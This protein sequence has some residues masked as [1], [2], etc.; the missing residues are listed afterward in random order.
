VLSPLDHARRMRAAAY[1]IGAL[2]IMVPLVE[3]VFAALP[4]HLHE[5]PWRLGALNALAGAVG[6]PLVG[7]FL[8]FAIALVTS[9]RLVLWLVFS[10]CAVAGALCLVGT[11]AFALDALQMHGQV[12]AGVGTKYWIASGWAVFKISFCALAFLILAAR[13]VGGARS[14]RRSSPRA[15]G[16][17]RP[18]V[19]SRLA[20]SASRSRAPEA[21]PVADGE[22]PIETR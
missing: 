9:D 3:T 22:R 13:S 21:K 20:P 10:F 18:V 14:V 17:P 8:C 7:L 4:A 19:V 15:P 5:P 2:L 11:G 16:D 1:V 6:L 12:R